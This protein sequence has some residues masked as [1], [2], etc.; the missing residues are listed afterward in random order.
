LTQ[1]R[2]GDVWSLH[3]GPWPSHS[4]AQGRPLMAPG[5]DQIS[6]MASPSASEEQSRGRAGL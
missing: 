4:Q 1:D 6:E 2:D 3:W 5:L